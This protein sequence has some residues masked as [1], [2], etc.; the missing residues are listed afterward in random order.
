[1][2]ND[3]VLCAIPGPKKLEQMMQ[4]VTKVTKYI[5]ARALKKKT[6]SEFTE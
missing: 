6:I 4:I 2:Y 1:L 3:E 5:S